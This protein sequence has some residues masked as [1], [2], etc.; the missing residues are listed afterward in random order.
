MQ[1]V[2]TKKLSIFETRLKPTEQKDKSK[3]DAHT[4]GPRLSQK[5]KKLSKKKKDKKSK[6]QAVKANHLELTVFE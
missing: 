3:S 4:A 6:K 1:S 5:R 2:E